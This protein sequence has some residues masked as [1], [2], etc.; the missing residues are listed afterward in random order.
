[1]IITNSVQETHAL[2][3]EV[4][5]QVRRGGVICLSGDLG[6]GKT[7]FTQELAK[8]LGV[9]RNVNSPTFLVVRSYRLAESEQAAK[10]L[11]HVD[12]YRLNSE[13]EIEEIG[14]TDMLADTEAVV[15]IEWSEKLGSLRPKK[16]IDI[17][18]EYLEE[19]KR[20]IKIDD[21]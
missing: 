16:R 18:F 13:Q 4:A 5:E 9:K 10:V 7:T 3:R 1:M 11:Y 19:K 15:V 17:H 12:L 21:H 14:L 6:S 8:T 20:R 2:A